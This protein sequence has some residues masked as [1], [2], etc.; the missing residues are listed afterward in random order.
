[1]NGWLKK[2]RQ[3]Q[4]HGVDPDEVDALLPVSSKAPELQ[5][6]IPDED[7][8]DDQDLE[9]LNNLASQVAVDELRRPTEQ[10]R[11]PRPLPSPPRYV[12]DQDEALR[13][14]RETAVFETDP[15][16]EL[17]KRVAPV[18]IDELIDDLATTAAALRKRKA[19]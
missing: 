13:V 2:A 1:M 6:F 17:S 3:R 8:D 9:F 7:H 19:A 5:R 16:T 14:F 12:S 10:E 18:A 11:K 4:S 15:R